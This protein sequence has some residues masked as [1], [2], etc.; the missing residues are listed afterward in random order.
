MEDSVRDRDS[1][2]FTTPSEIPGDLGVRCAAVGN[3]VLRLWA[4]LVGVRILDRLPDIVP[5]SGSV[6]FLRIGLVALGGE[7]CDMG[8]DGG[9]DTEDFG[10]TISTSIL[11]RF[12]GGRVSSTSG[13]ERR[14]FLRPYVRF[15][16]ATV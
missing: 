7:K 12:R 9:G 11:G 5:I 3:S 16:V 8:I 15:I 10:R 1:I 2:R 13:R 4:G 14:E 6:A